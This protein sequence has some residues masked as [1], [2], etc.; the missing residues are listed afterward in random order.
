M[1]ERSA[2][3]G[4]R[5]RGFLGLCAAGA[6]GGA[7]AAR[8]GGGSWFVLPVAGLVGALLC[9]MAGAALGMLLGKVLRFSGRGGGGFDVEGGLVLAAYGAFLGVVSALVL[10][11]GVQGHWWAMGGAALGGV[12]AG[13]LGEGVQLLT[14]LLLLS[15]MSDAD[16]ARAM[17]RAASR[18][19][20]N[21]LWPGDADSQEE[22][23]GR[24]YKGD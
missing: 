17:R 11:Q 24:E 6:A 16:R 20:E 19:R 13:M 3:E 14:R 21:L 23:E 22:R 12:V 15:S 10:G 9:C 7:V 1:S 5:A 4:L 2:L 8:V 18:V